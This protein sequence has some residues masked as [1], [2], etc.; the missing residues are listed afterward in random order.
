MREVCARSRG[1]P[2]T[3]RS[4]QGLEKNPIKLIGVQAASK[5]L[6]LSI[7]PDDVA[8]IFAAR[9]QDAVPHAPAERVGK[10]ARILRNTLSHNFGPSNVAVITATAGFYVPKMRSFLSG[11]GEVLEYQKAHFNSIP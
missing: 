1:D 9:T 6:R 2:Q 5:T 8:Y 4:R 10:S 11:I 3:R 7:A